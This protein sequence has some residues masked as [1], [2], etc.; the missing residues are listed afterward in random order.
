MS[1]VNPY[2]QLLNRTRKEVTS[3]LYQEFLG[4]GF[5]EGP[6]DFNETLLTFLV[7][8]II[9]PEHE[10]FFQTLY[11]VTLDRVSST[12][13]EG[14]RLD[15]QRFQNVF[16]REYLRGKFTSESFFEKVS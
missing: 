1:P 7:S 14:E 8:P 16:Y 10:Y 6:E 4:S 15:V 9:T 13:G 3:C 11:R 12:L 2:L 5:V